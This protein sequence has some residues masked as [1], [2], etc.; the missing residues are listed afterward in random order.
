MG[1]LMLQDAI[2]QE[3]TTRFLQKCMI[4]ALLLFIVGAA[5][6]IFF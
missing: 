3:R 6:W 2:R 5:K 4:V 1:E